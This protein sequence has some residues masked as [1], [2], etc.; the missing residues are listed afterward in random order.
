M[1]WLLTRIGGNKEAEESPPCIRA[2][3]KGKTLNKLARTGAPI[4]T[5]AFYDETITDH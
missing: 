5:R 3:I 2:T 1:A 4:C